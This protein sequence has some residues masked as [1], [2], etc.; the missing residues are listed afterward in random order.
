MLSSL[1][2]LYAHNA[3]FP[4]PSDKINE[5]PFNMVGKVATKEVLSGDNY[6]SWWE[7]S[8]VAIS[9]KVVLSATHVFFDNETVDWRPSPFRW[10]L[11]HSPSNQSF[12]IKARSYRY[13][14]DYAEATRR[15]QPDDLSK[16]SYEQFNI[17]VITLIF[18]EDVA[19]G[20]H[21]GWWSDHMTDNMD[22]MIVGYPNINYSDSDPRRHRMHSTSLSGSPAE[23]TLANYNDRFGFTR[24][25]YSTEDLS[26]GPGMSGGP[27][28]G[29]VNFP[30]G[31]DWVVV[32]VNV[33]GNIGEHATVVGID[34]AVS[35]LIYDAI[36]T[37]DSTPIDDHGDSH[38]EATAI[39]LNQT[40]SG[41]LER[42]GDIDY[43]KFA[44]TKQGTLTTFTTGNTDTFGTLRNSQGN[45]IVSNDDSG[46]GENFSI[47]RSL[48]PGT[49]YILVSHALS[50]G[51]GTYSLRVN[52][53]EKVTYPDL[54]VDSVRVNKTSVKSGDTVQVTL[55]RSNKGDKN[56]PVFNHG[57]YLSRDRTIT[58]SDR[59]LANLSATSMN[60]G[61]SRTFSQLV[62]IPK[63]TTPGTYYIGYIV[64]TGK[65]IREKSETNN[66]GYT[67]I[68]VVKP[69]FPDL[70]VNFVG[71]DRRQV[72]AGEAVRVESDISNR[73]DK[74]SGAY[75]EGLY[76]SKD[77]IITTADTRLASF[78]KPSLR[79]S[80]EKRFYYNVV[81][82]KN[83]TSGTYNL[84]HILDIDGL[85]TETNESNNT[86]YT[87]ITVVKPSVLDLAV[88]FVGVDRRQVRAG[89]S[90]LVDC[91]RSNK[92][93]ERS[94]GFDHGIYLSKD[95][96]IN[97][98]DKQLLKLG[99]ISMGAGALINASYKVTIPKNTTS[100]IYYV[101]YIL[102]IGD[103]IRET[104]ESNNTGYTQIEVVRVE[105]ALDLILE[106]SGYVAG[107]NI[108]HPNGNVFNQILLTGQ[109]IKFKAKSQQITRVSF[110]DVN[111]DIVQVEFSG[112]GTIK[113]TLDSSTYSG[114][115]YPSRYNQQINYVTGKPSIVIEGADSTTFLSIFTVG[116]I[117]AVNQTL[118]P[119]GQV[120]DAQA[121]IKLVEVINSTGFGGM[122]FANAVFSG[123][124][125]KVG[126]DARDV[127]I[128]VR[129]TIGDIDASGNA[130][131]YL[132]FG[133][134]SF[135]SSANNSGLR[136]TGGDLF[137]TNGAEIVA[138]YEAASLIS[139]ANVRSD[140]S[141]MPVLAIRGNF[142][143]IDQVNSGRFDDKKY[144][145]KVDDASD[146]Y[147]A[148]FSFDS[149]SETF[150]LIETQAIG[151]VIIVNTLTG[152]F[153]ELDSDDGLDFSIVHL[154][155]EYISNTVGGSVIIEGTPDEIN[156]L[157]A[158]PTYKA[159]MVDMTFKTSD[160]GSFWIITF[161]T[162]ESTGSSTGT[163][164]IFR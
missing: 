99:K 27:V 148:T 11:R 143:Y 20:G 4:L 71:V 61:A 132:L 79:A 19:Y 57:I 50:Q 26:A 7:G 154:T 2:C 53:V 83:T 125:G 101:G 109:F 18:F 100:G 114:P 80:S 1:Q 74:D 51:T 47:K 89:D 21:A 54:A 6:Y 32:G 36:S 25:V 158:L 134:G 77:A 17:D 131:P 42:D 84:G 66:T 40:V 156:S 104:N 59:S 129:L 96:T 149:V 31:T 3:A 72:R 137:Q 45:F 63:N 69:S 152:E 138:I 120:Y 107:E 9:Q 119:S 122:Q 24:R 30:S 58:T 52:F 29:L 13:F 5:Y 94:S 37:T 92:G 49:Y 126:V 70:A 155:V 44:L 151:E 93:N 123:S 86:G 41:D 160:S 127:P 117:N 140:G 141:N 121:D 136:I 56:S 162:D 161:Y 142:D 164:Y 87:A 90:I 97:S 33:G 150:E 95:R 163:F 118:F 60:A 106:G 75:T 105:P 111:G 88:D 145:F 64:D 113:V 116:K 124:T 108:Q 82:P 110:L 153:Y 48:T 43:F 16:Y 103:I 38:S 23:F 85:I 135:T 102:D 144:I 15:F 28:F 65:K 39:Q 8:G 35:D 98:R 62:T 10:N 78:T 130:V 128:A 22:K 34:Q 91:Q 115:A 67:Q 12:D 68:T 46:Q 157:Y 133:P 76:L 14:D 81:I 73:G 147:S 112:A 55:K 139:Q 159:F 146:D